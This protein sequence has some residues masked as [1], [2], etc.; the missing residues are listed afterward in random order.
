MRHSKSENGSETPTAA[1]RG[2]TKTTVEIADDLFGRAK[3][4]AGREGTTLRALIEEGLRLALERRQRGESYRL[5]D[6]SFAG[7]GLRPEVREGNWAQ[8]RDLIYEGHGA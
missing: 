6:A 7:D 5:R 1:K 2:V 8:I 4:M 3:E